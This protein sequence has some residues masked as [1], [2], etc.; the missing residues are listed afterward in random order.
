MS[1]SSTI[2]AKLTP[3]QLI[4][5]EKWEAEREERDR[6]V[7]LMIEAEKSGDNKVFKELL[8]QILDTSPSMCEHGRSIASPCK[9]CHQIE[10]ILHPECFC[11]ECE[12]N[13]DLEELQSHNGYCLNCS[14]YLSG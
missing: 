5:A 9:A 4:I 12:E 11:K 13:C 3:E 10:M 8:K 6:L 7:S 1:I 2:R 14:D